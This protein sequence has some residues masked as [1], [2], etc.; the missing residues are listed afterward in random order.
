[1]ERGMKT[2]VITGST[3]GIGFG[4]AREFLARGC[5]VIISGRKQAAVERA[6]AT[7]S[8]GSEVKRVAGIA[9]EVCDHQQVQ[10]LWDFAARTFGGVDIWINNAG[11]SHGAPHLEDVPLAELQAVAQTNMMG[12][13]YGATVAMRGFRS[14]GRGALYNL[15]GLGSDGRR[16]DGLH[17]YGLTKRAVAYLTD[18]LADEARGSGVIVG[19]IQPGMVMTDMITRSYANRPEEWARS[20]AVLEVIS[21]RVETVAPVLAQKVLA[22]TKNRARLRFGGMLRM[23]LKMPR[24]MAARKQ[25]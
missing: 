10:E 3:R 23:I 18:S 5:A 4:L 16:M 2:I 14:Q 19:A 22:N 25:G 8:A 12:T 13:L 20:R 11:I 7:L 17:L 1:M 6:V 21:E 24:L 15:E 9:C